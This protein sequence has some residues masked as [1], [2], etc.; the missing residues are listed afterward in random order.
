MVPTTIISQTH[1]LKKVETKYRLIDFPN[2]YVMEVLR[3]KLNLKKGGGD[4]GSISEAILFF[5]KHKWVKMLLGLCVH[6]D[7]SL[8]CIKAV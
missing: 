4:A 2:P 5:R 7:L 1:S 3:E 6:S 8:T